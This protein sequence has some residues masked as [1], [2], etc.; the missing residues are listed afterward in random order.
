[1]DRHPVWV[2]VVG[3]LVSSAASVA[4]CQ[5]KSSS[6]K[7]AAKVE[8]TNYDRLRVGD[9]TDGRIV[10]PT[11]Q[12]LL[13][14]GRQVAISGRPTDVALSADG[15]WLAVL[16]NSRV[17]V[18]DPAAGTIASRV[19][20]AGGGSFTGPS[21]PACPHGAARVRPPDPGRLEREPERTGQ[22]RRPP[23]P[24]PRRRRDRRCVQRI[25]P[26]VCQRVVQRIGVIACKPYCCP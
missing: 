5:E 7:P 25:V 11:N 12:V 10:V 14:A 19:S 20:L 15:R 1:M 17:A 26:S 22:H 18:I 8:A 3:L 21:P 6:S 23:T 4:T 2:I 24:L 9:S 16:E 13:P